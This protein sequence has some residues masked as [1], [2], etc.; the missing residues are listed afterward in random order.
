MAR[1]LQTSNRTEYYSLANLDY[2]FPEC[3][4]TQLYDLIPEASAEAIDLMESM[5]QYSPRNRPS[6]A[7][8]LKHPFFEKMNLVSETVENKENKAYTKF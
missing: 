7:D 4:K 8:I 5:L 1:R 6:A 3:K 2:K